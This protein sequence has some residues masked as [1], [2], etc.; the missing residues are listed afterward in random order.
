[1]AVEA[2]SAAL[3]VVEPSSLDCDASSGSGAT[4]V[5]TPRG[6]VDVTSRLVG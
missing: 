3:V 5:L 4:P 1:M 2:D 6:S